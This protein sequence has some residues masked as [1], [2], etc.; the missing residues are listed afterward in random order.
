MDRGAGG[1]IGE[2]GTCASSGRP[3]HW[4]NPVGAAQDTKDAVRPRHVDRP[5]NFTA[6]RVAPREI[7]LIVAHF[8]HG[9]YYIFLSNK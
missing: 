1:R 5:A 8:A 4:R 6:N 3:R 7:K 2:G 9:P